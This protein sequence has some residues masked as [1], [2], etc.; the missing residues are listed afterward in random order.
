MKIKAKLEL[1]K[2]ALVT[3]GSSGIGKAIAC[4]LASRGMDVWL[5][6]Q[7]KDLLDSARMEV[8]THRRNQSQKVDTL[9]ADVSDLEQV[10]VAVKQV[11]EKSG[12]PDLLVNS[13]G[14]AHPGYVQELDI[15]IFNW[16]MEVNYFGTVYVTKEVIPA[17]LKRASGYIVN[18]SSVAGFVGTFGYT[19]YGAS[20]FAVRGFSDALRAE[21]KLYGIGVS[22]IFPP[23]TE[24]PQLEYESRFKPLETKALGGNTKVMSPEKVADEAIRGIERGRYIILPSLD[25]KFIYGLNGFF[26]GGLRLIMDRIIS[27]ANAKS[28]STRS[29]EV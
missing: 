11:S 8:E 22:I 6:A 21:M 23:D 20:K 3:G 26:G 7:R 16:M 25:S 10:R 15:N 19:A 14:V 2:V 12:P 29:K 13:A 24:T 27:K 17:M 4:G 5:V 9:S 28:I 1:G 18:I